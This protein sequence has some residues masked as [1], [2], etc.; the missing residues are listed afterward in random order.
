MGGGLDVVGGHIRH[1]GDRLEDHVQLGG[2]VV[3]LLRGEVDAGQ[4]CQPRDLVLAQRHG[5]LLGS[6]DVM[7]GKRHVRCGGR[8]GPPRPSS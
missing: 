4:L 6:G 1:P 5:A 3:Q 8:M 2:Q 7:S